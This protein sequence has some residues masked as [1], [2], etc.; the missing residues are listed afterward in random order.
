[1]RTDTES[2]ARA[3]GAAEPLQLD[4]PAGVL[5]GAAGRVSLTPSE[6]SPLAV[7]AE[8]VEPA[9]TAVLAIAALGYGDASAE[10]IVRTNLSNVRRKRR[11]DGLPDPI[12]GRRGRGYRGFGLRLVRSSAS[13]REAS[14]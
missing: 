10:Q 3:L 6:A 2:V 14:K 12:A 11:E 13:K 5:A 7:L 4:A 8:A 1:M 9:A